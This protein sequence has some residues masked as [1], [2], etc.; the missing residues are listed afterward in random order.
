VL[1]QPI[2]D[3]RTGAV[4]GAEALLRWQHPSAGLTTPGEFIRV[5]EETGLIV[6]IGRWVLEQAAET[7]A[8]CTRR[9]GSTAI[10]STAR[11]CG[12]RTRSKQPG[13]DAQRNDHIG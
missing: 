10:R 13:H 8:V 4:D 3:L 5:A 11:D 12:R 9:G 1:Y 2:V 7:L 6:P